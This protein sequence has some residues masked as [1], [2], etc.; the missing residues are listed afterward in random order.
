MERYHERVPN[1]WW[2]RALLYGG[3]L[4]DV[5]AIVAAALDG[6]LGDAAWAFYPAMG[7]AL[8]VVG[9]TAFNFSYLDIRVTEAELRFGFGWFG[10][11][12][13]LHAIAEMQVARYEWMQYGGWGIRFRTKGRRA[14]SV[15]G[16]PEGVVVTAERNGKGRHYFVSSQRPHL[17]REALQVRRPLART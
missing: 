17:L 9:A 2:L 6:G 15:P 3:I 11:R 8:L 12:I 1:P 13:P 14:W 10:K 16:V 5:V 4:A 7:L